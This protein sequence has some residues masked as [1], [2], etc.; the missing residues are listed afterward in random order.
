MEEYNTCTT[1]VY[2]ETLK[3]IC[4]CLPLDIWFDE[5][6]GLNWEMFQ[7]NWLIQVPLCSRKNMNCVQSLKLDFSS[8]ILPCSGLVLTSFA[9]QENSKNI[10][11]SLPEE[12]HFY[13]IYKKHLPFPPALS[14][15]IVSKVSKKVTKQLYISI[16]QSMNGGTSWDMWGSILTRPR[17]TE[18]P[19]TE[20]P[21]QWTCCP[22]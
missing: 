17:S 13:Q 22:Q 14:G 11:E 10:E 21:S 1:R 3:N 9:K 18:S 6:V 15:S 5:K 16:F 12:F 19:K 20:R 4:G 7:N 8:C 2:S